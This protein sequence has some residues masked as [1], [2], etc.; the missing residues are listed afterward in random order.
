MEK[1]I[2]A[3]A[4]AMRSD[5]MPVHVFVGNLP[6]LFN[7]LS[8]SI[9]QEKHSTILTYLLTYYTYILTYLLDL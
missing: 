6:T 3:R 2:F 1:E 9:L 4:M 7:F 8:W 5:K